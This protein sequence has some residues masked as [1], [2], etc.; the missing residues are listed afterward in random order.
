M[1]GVASVVK[2]PFVG[3]RPLQPGEPIFGR[4]REIEELLSLLIAERIVLLHAPSGC[5]KS[6]LLEAGLRGPLAERGFNVLPTVR[7]GEPQEATATLERHAAGSAKDSYDLLFLDQ[8]EEV[9]S[10]AHD[11]AEAFLKDLGRKLQNRRVWAV[12]AIREDR[13]GYLEPH[14]RVFSNHLRVRYRLA[15]LRPADAVEAMKETAAL[16]G[17]TF[18]DEAA[19]K[20]AL[21]LAGAAGAVEPVHLQVVCEDL[22]NQK[23]PDPQTIVPDDIILTGGAVS[24]I[25]VALMKYYANRLE[26]IAGTD[27]EQQRVLR[28]FFSDELLDAREGRRKQVSVGPGLKLDK[29]TIDKLVNCFL[30]RRVDRNGDWIELAHDRLVEPVL[31]ANAEWFAERTKPWQLAADAWKQ[32]GMPASMLTLQGDKL[33]SA[34]EYAKAYPARI[35][36]V[37]QQFLKACESEQQR[38]VEKRRLEGLV[39]F[40]MLALVVLLIG[41]LAYVAY[42]SRQLSERDQKLLRSEQRNHDQE[43]LIETNKAA[44]DVEIKRLGKEAERNY[45]EAKSARLQADAARAEAAIA[46]AQANSKVL[47]ADARAKSSI[48]KADA[49]ARDIAERAMND[50]AKLVQDTKRDAKL[51]YDKKLQEADAVAKTE[52]RKILDSAKAQELITHA[53]GLIAGGLRQSELGSVTAGIRELLNVKSA[54]IARPLQ[55]ALAALRDVWQRSLLVGERTHGRLVL[56]IG[57]DDKGAVAV[58]DDAGYLDSKPTQSLGAGMRFPDKGDGRTVRSPSSGVIGAGRAAVGFVDGHISP[59]PLESTDFKD[60]E[61]FRHEVNALA[62]SPRTSRYIAGASTFWKTKVWDTEQWT[63]KP[64]IVFRTPGKPFPGGWLWWLRT[65]TGNSTHLYTS[66]AL[67]E[68]EKG[69][70]RSVLFAA[71]RQDGTVTVYDVQSRKTVIKV[72]GEVSSEKDSCYRGNDSTRHAL[73]IT[74]VAFSPDGRS[75]VTGGKDGQRVVWTLPDS[76]RCTE[77]Q[78]Q[79]LTAATVLLEQLTPPSAILSVAFHPSGRMLALGEE[80]GL[81]RLYESPTGKGFSYVTTLDASGSVTNLIFDPKE[82][83]LHAV[84]G[85]SNVQQWYIPPS[86]RLASRQEIYAELLK[87]NMSTPTREDA[88]SMLSKVEPHLFEIVERRAKE[89]SRS[90]RSQ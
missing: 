4:R 74:A 24:A 34:I 55:E 67:W 1:S 38:L 57:L 23:R 41:G 51:E 3:P 16:G 56:S 63:N 76:R 52:A 85:R 33:Q 2:N 89:G 65:F 82:P 30:I 75:L 48:E 25:D 35:V 60:Y 64:R 21:Y 7:V 13:L 6:S 28:K 80:N 20:L 11:V 46:L 58:L 62:L 79:K 14:A 9:F 19:Q 18:T 26:L 88:A 87:I 73:S 54:E 27:E 8:F 47:A 71:G 68:P 36:E 72:R 81:I 78:A 22:W 44:S 61:A 10:A 77:I 29:D 43:K 40:A 83:V 31:R 90:K 12:L 17:V 66:L 42:T 15:Q 5:G 45:G 86:S 37:D 69:D 53:Q 59:G 84:S 39:K 70:S 50:A 49:D 32:A